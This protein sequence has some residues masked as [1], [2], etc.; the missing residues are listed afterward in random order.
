MLWAREKFFQLEKNRWCAPHKALPSVEGVSDLALP[1]VIVSDEAGASRALV[2]NAAPLLACPVDLQSEKTLFRFGECMKTTQPFCLVQLALLSGATA[3]RNPS[4]RA[5]RALFMSVLELCRRVAHACG[6]YRAAKGLLASNSQDGG[7]A[8][9]QWMS[10]P[11]G[12][13]EMTALAR[14]Y[15]SPITNIMQGKSNF[16]TCTSSH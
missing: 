5:E 15:Y 1:V 16:K 7:Q 14:R 8:R 4:L 9:H 2:C 3:G 11:S 10:D 13:F 6:L 12:R